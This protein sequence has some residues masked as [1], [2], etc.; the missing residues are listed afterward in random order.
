ME[1]QLFG[2]VAKCTQFEHQAQFPWACPLC[3]KNESIGTIYHSVKQGN[4]WIRYHPHCLA[5]WDKNQGASYGKSMFNDSFLFF[6]FH[7]VKQGNDWIRYHPHCL[8][9]WDKNQG[10]SYGN[11]WGAKNRFKNLTPHG[12]AEFST[13]QPNITTTKMAKQ[14]SRTMEPQLFGPV[15]KGT[16]FEHQAQF[17]W[18]CPLCRKNESIGTIYHS[19]K[20]GNDWIRYHPH[21]LAQWDKNQGASYDDPYDDEFW[22]EVDKRF[23]Q[24]DDSGEYY[25]GGDASD[26]EES[27]LNQSECC[28]GGHGGG[29]DDDVGGGEGGEGE[30]GGGGGEGGFEGVG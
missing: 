16:R 24:N 2:L 11:E 26:N 17:P 6:F 1:P 25:G 23:N 29:G 30:G 22:D 14:T 19:V 7:S 20:Q 12:T 8:A 15:A 3:R 27:D 13:N 28:G 10:A 9:Q 5:Q 21:C 18:A 4:D